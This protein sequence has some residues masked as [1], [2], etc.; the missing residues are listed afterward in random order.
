MGT[1]RVGSTVCVLTTAQCEQGACLHAI[2]TAQCAGNTGE[3]K[4]VLR[5]QLLMTVSGGSLWHLLATSIF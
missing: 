5:K 1:F 3:E 2:L 4:S